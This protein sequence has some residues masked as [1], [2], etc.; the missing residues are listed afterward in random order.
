ME[1]KRR[2]GIAKL[3]RAAVGFVKIEKGKADR[4]TG[5]EYITPGC[6][7]RVSIAWQVYRGPVQRG[8][9]HR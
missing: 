5:G 3:C 1:L 7:V 4:V 8:Q 9:L 2:N 6:I